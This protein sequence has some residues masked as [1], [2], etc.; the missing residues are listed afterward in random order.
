[1]VDKYIAVSEAVR[2]FTLAR[3]KLPEDKIV[4]IYNGIDCAGVPAAAPESFSGDRNCCNI[5][6]A[7]RF[8]RQKGHAFFIKALKQVKQQHANLKAYLFGE[9]PDEQRIRDMVNREGLS[10]QVAFMGVVY[11][12]LPY[13]LQMNICVLPSLWEGLPNVLLEAMAARVPIVATRIPGVDE[14][15]LDGKTGI[16]C[17]P[18]NARALAEAL[19]QLIRTPEHA[20]AMAAAARLRVEQRFSLDAAVRST[21]AVYDRLLRHSNSATG[22]ERI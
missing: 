2:Q 6:L 5:I 18:G 17:E 14:L 12:I 21:V 10:D 13:M 19:L 11:N 22:R 7:G 3:V 1:M 15:V 9:G 4:T 8:E 16:L 20:R